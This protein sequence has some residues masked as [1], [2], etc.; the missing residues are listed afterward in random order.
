MSTFSTLRALHA[1]IG[2]AI[3]DIHRVFTDSPPSSPRKFDF[4]PSS[5]YKQ[6]FS[7]PSPRELSFPSPSTCTFPSP[8]TSDFPCSSLDREI[9]FPNPYVPYD[10]SSP[11]ELLAAHPQ[12]AA[13]AS[14]IVAACGQLA[15]IVQK[16]F[17]VLCDASMGYNLPAS[18]RLLEHIHIVEILREAEDARLFAPPKGLHVN[19]IARIIRENTNTARVDEVR[20]AHALRLLATHHLLRETAPDVFA[21]SRVSSLLDTGKTVASCFAN[22]GKKY[23]DTDGVAAFSI[24]P[25]SNPKPLPQ[26]DPE[27]IETLPAFNIAFQTSAPFF[28]WLEDGGKD[29]RAGRSFLPLNTNIATEL[30]RPTIHPTSMKTGF[31]W[32]SLP[33]GATIVD[34]GG[35]IGST[36]MLLA[37]AFVQDRPVVVGLGLQAWRAQCP[38]MLDEG[39]VEFQEHDFFAPQ[40]VLRPALFLLRVVL[41]D[42]PDD[43]ARRILLR[44]RDAAGD[45]TKLIIA[46]HVLPLACVDEEVSEKDAEKT[47]APAP[48]LPNLGKASANAYW[49]DLTMHSI[50]N[51]KERTLRELCALALSAGWRATRITRAEGSVFGH[52]VCE[53][54]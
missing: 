50:F 23:E 9:D 20:L 27:T 4:Y 45:E 40:P 35:G 42:W 3:D 30:T 19:D 49:L 39:R 2:D 43:A 13:A 1:L 18:L 15:T 22:P 41:H 51:G 14:R 37:R 26:I 48:L 11:A 53:P 32:S 54:I 44:L 21:G 33:Q 10:P 34:V 46:D 24:S 38:E 31:D 16:P 6:R 47:L 29:V 8:S 7:S 25:L 5:P 17:L 52:L 28:E 36:T 12:A